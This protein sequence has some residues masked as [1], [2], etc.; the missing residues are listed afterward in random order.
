M[1]NPSFM[2][3]FFD[4]VELIACISFLVPVIP[5]W[6]LIKRMSRTL[7]LLVII[8]SLMLLF[9]VGGYYTGTHYIPNLWIY[10]GGYVLTFYLFSV[11]FRRLLAT[12]LAKWLTGSLMVLFGVFTALRIKDIITPGNFDSYTPAFLSIAM[13]AYCILYFNRQLGQPQITFIYKTPWFWVVTGLLLYYAGSFLILLTT[14]YLML[15]DTVFTWG[16][17][18]LLDGLTIMRNLLIALGFA[19]YKNISWKTSF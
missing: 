18:D 11:L 17:W 10:F 14:D 19:F 13:M 5:G 2:R 1:T 6:V 8:L 7:R 4:H 15:R 16:L 9:A 3:A 12:P